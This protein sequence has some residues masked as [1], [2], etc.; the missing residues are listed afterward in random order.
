MLAFLPFHIAVVEIDGPKPV[1][2][3][4]PRYPVGDK[5]FPVSVVAHDDAHFLVYLLPH[6]KSSATMGYMNFML[7]DDGC[8]RYTLAASGDQLAKHYKVNAL[9]ERTPVSYDVKPG[10]TLPVVDVSTD[11][12]HQLELMKWGLIPSW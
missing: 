12:E 3:V 11:G 7:Y 4:L 6:S 8:G 2:S 5:V 1:I 10:Q 9:S